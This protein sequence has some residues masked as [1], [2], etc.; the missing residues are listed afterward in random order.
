[1]I[2]PS[3]YIDPKA[4]IHE[5][6]SIGHF[7]VIGPDVEIDEGTWIGPHVVIPG[8]T[9]IGKHNKIYQH[10]SI[11]EGPQDKKYNDEPT[12]LE[13]GDNNVIREFVSIHRGTVQDRKV[14]SIGSNNL[15]MTLVHVA[16]D[17]VVGDNV[18]LANGCAIGGHVVVE[19]WAIMAGYSGSHQF[20]RVGAH[21]FVGMQVAITKDVPPFVMVAGSEGAPRGINA[22]G[23]RRRNFSSDAISQ[24]KKAYKLLYRS[25]LTLA[26][27]LTE[28]E[29]QCEDTPDIKALLSFIK[30]SPRGI[31]R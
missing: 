23:L 5:S 8:P 13:I 26:Q 21:A 2:A 27:A 24:I 17:C 11:G 10:S 28:I 29:Q 1:M 18:I 30:A 12:L 14:T 4:K 7:S 31:V 22:E 3:A 9:K 20:C 16:H 25:K 15:L 19:D 6:V